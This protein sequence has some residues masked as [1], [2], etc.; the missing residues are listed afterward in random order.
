MLQDG[1][2]LCCKVGLK[3]LQGKINGILKQDYICNAI[4]LVILI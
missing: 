1:E 3:K 4:G 2:G